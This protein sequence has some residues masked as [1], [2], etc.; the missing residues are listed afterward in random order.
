MK[1]SN[2][3]GEWLVG[4]LLTLNYC[5]AYNTQSIRV[6]FGIKTVFPYGLHQRRRKLQIA[7]GVNRA[8]VTIIDLKS[9]VNE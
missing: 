2:F 7:E 6:P 8:L 5:I 1:T 9:H 3:V 4:W